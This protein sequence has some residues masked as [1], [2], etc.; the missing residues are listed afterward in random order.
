MLNNNK[1]NN[2]MNTKNSLWLLVA[3]I[4]I[5]L[6]SCRKDRKESLSNTITVDNSTAENLYSDL[7]K[8]VDNVSSTED[9]IRENEIGCIDTIIV[10]TV[11]VPRSILIDFGNDDCT[12][13]DGRIRKGQILATFTGRY[14]EEG[15]IITVTPQNYTVNGYSLSGSK[16]ITNL[17]ENSD[18]HL[19]YSISVDG[20]ITAPGNSWTSSWESNRTRTW[21]EGESTATIWDDVYEITGSASGVSRNGVN[22]DIIVT[23]PL[24]AEI[25]CRWI[26]SG[27]MTL[28]PEGYDQ[29]VIDFG[30]GECNNGFTVTVN[31][32]TNSY[33]SED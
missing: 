16:T 4:L 9:G 32:E 25:G 13:E 19:H 20:S 5:T 8:V 6:A 28:V 17:G 27:S 3:F 31:G 2:P 14:R 11:S 18:G 12:G 30:N 24:R 33:G 22:Y 15:T 21:I 10:D 26:V 7:F 1:M 29:R 23:S